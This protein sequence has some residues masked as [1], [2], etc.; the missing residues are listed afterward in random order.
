MLIR[1]GDRLINTRNWAELVKPEKLVR[2]LKASSNYGR[3]ICEP[4]ERGFGTTLGNA[5]RRVLLSS[6]QGAAI[7]AAR[8]E[9]VQHEFTTIPGVIED[10]TEIV[11]N[12]K[13]VRLAMASEDPQRLVLSSNTKGVV[14]AAAIKEN[15]HVT[16]LDP[17]QHIAT[18]SEDRE[19]RVELDVRMGKGYVP[20]DMHEGL[21]NEIGLILLDASYSP[22]KKVAYTVD[23]ARVGQMTNYDKLVL[24]VWTD[25]SISPDDAVSYSAKILKEQLTVFINFNENES[26]AESA[27]RANDIELNPNLFKS[28]DEL[29]LSVRAT[30]CL[31]SANITL[32]GELMQRSE[33]EM[34]KTKNFGKKSLEEIRR[35]LEDMGLE[36]G[37]RLDNFEQKYQEWVKRKQ[38]D[39]A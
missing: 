18:L 21:E 37:M 4:L 7:V 6:L 30:N 35:V 1:N 11:L 22:V 3:F 10:V 14:T 2:E 32:V 5:L 39:E 25:G 23:Q 8:I 38:V 9:G 29:E 34:L 17:E 31:K 36:F 12:L 26:E 16:V 13:Q 20:A 15:Q 33:N 24:D 27:R 19:F 28:I